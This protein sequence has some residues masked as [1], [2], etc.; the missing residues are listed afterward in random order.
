MKM[1]DNLPARSIWY[2]TSMN[3]HSI[4]K[5]CS[6]CLLLVTVSCA[7]REYAIPEPIASQIDTSLTFDQLQAAPT[8]YVG[9]VV[10]LGGEVVNVKRLRDGTSMEILQ[11]P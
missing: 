7:S 1:G 4:I 8:S 3:G 10:A 5:A 11:L 6:A 2:S 9:K